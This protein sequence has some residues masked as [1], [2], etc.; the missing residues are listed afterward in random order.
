[1]VIGGGCDGRPICSAAKRASDTGI[2][3]APK[4]AGER[5]AGRVWSEG[6]GF[7]QEYRT[8]HSRH[9]HVRDHDGSAALL[10]EHCETLY[11]TR[12][13]RAWAEWP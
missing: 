8:V 1:M 13:G 10:L 6:P 12:G 7:R 5:K 2:S 3:E 9:S 4:C 11:T